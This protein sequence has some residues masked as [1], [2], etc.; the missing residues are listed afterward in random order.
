M[1]SDATLSCPRDKVTMR[2]KVVGGAHLDECAK[3]KGQF[4]DSG[5][6]FSAFGIKADPSYWDRPETGGSVKPSTLACS[7]CGS[8]MLGQDVAYEGTHVEID[9]CGNCGGVWLD[10]GEIDTIIKISEKMQPMLDAEQA[11]AKAELDALG[12]NFGSPGLIG[13]FLRLFTKG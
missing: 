7:R 3:C 2:Q 6:M 1:S 11:K 8:I 5:E 4:F 10:K 13:K 12:D 9:R